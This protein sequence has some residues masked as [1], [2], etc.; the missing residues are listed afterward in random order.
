MR[1][2]ARLAVALLLLTSA[3]ASA[4]PSRAIAVT[5]DGRVYFTD[6]ERLWLIGRDGRLREL[7]DRD[8]HTH[9]IALDPAGN[10]IG[11]DSAYDPATG[12]YRGEL[13]QISPSGRFRTIYPLTDRMER[14]VGVVR[15][16]L[17]CT[18]QVNETAG[19]RRPLVHRRCPNGRIERLVGS[20]ADDR[21][22]NKQLLS[23][24]AG[25]ALG[26][27][28]SFYFRQDTTARRI[29]PDGAVRV[30]ASGIVRENYGIALDRDGSILVAEGAARR[31]V[32]VS[33]GG[34]RTLAA[35]SAKPWFP[36]GIAVGRDGLY[37]LEATDYQ[38]GVET[39]VRVRRVTP[40]RG[41]TVLA[42][43]AVPLP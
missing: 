34:R 36:T 6:L 14:G 23:N 29:S 19:T 37:L 39:R 11:E 15:D 2:A 8:R 24:V 27:D 32:R 1:F 30:V 18:Y 12:V 38:R 31:L 43:V 33:P 20:A 25:A 9:E 21:S 13:W 28:G 10:V 7:R 41:S 16:A 40:G 5:D 35:T 3:G 17:G 26:P 42:T 22:F 4:H